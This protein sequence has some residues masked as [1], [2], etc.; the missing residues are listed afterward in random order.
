[1][2]PRGCLEIVDQPNGAPSPR[3]NHAPYSD[4][5]QRIRNQ[6]GLDLPTPHARDEHVS[7]GP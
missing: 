7:E 3:K 6:L 5:S 4:V 2:G 1:M